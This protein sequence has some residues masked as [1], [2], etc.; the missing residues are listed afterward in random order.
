MNRW[1]SAGILGLLLASVLLMGGLSG[2]PV[3]ALETT[4]F[5][6]VELD[7]GSEVSFGG[8]LSSTAVQDMG[9]VEGRMNFA[10]PGMPWPTH[11]VRCSEMSSDPDWE[12]FGGDFEGDDAANPLLRERIGRPILPARTE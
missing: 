4:A 3:Y 11:L 5:E 8:G 9:R 10:E 7:R 6:E 12:Y 2:L 1:R